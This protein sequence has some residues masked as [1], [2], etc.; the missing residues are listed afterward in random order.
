MKFNTEYLFLTFA[1]G[2]K[3]KENLY[4]YGRDDDPC[5]ER[6]RLTFRGEVPETIQVPNQVAGNKDLI[7]LMASVA[8]KADVTYFGEPT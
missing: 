8:P 4:T 7:N 3:R 5:I 1:S 2:A 6:I